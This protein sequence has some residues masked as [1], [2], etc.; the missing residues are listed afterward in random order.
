MPKPRWTD[1]PS[2]KEKLVDPPLN[3]QDEAIGRPKKE[4]NLAQ[5]VQDDSV[6]S[7]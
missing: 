6:Y 1:E 5:I 3:A 4:E 7:S 2:K